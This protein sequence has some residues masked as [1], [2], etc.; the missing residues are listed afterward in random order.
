[1]YL[2]A[3]MYVCTHVY[4]YVHMHTTCVP[5][6]HKGQKKPLHLSELEL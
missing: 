4:M 6:A 5:G 1:M 3:Y 2:Y